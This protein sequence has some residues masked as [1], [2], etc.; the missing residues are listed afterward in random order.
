MLREFQNYP[1]VIDVYR[2]EIK[3]RDYRGKAIIEHGPWLPSKPEADRWAK[4][5]KNMGYMAQVKDMEGKTNGRSD[6]TPYPR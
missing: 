4:I 1:K 5:F 6:L 3:R 2:V